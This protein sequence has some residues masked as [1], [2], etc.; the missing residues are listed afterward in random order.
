MPTVAFAIFLVVGFIV[1]YISL[2][3]G[4]PWQQLTRSYK[5]SWTR[6]SKSITSDGK[7][8]F[9]TVLQPYQLPPLRTR[10]S[11]RMAMGLKRLDE[12]N[13]L[14][15]D[16]AYLPE[17]SLRCHMLQYSRPNVLQ[18]LPGTEAACHEVLDLVT[19]FLSKRFPEHFTINQSKSVIHNHL[20][21]ESYIIGAECLNP[22]ET[23]ARLAME[24]FN[25][26]EKDAKTGEYLIKAS[27][28]LFP[29]GWQLQEKIGTSM[30]NLHSPVP[31]WQEKLG[32]AVNRHVP[33]LLTSENM[34]AN[35]NT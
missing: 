18:C 23:A 34:V 32:A 8:S 13:W 27:A 31:G 9:S 33:P 35:A 28:T 12:S 15:I 11:S 26:L 4:Q 19:S 2:R 16:I 6:E 22:M 24:D 17:H 7:H 29:A 30:A 21:K 3:H 10:T 1:I 25:I 20:T 5:L 14:T